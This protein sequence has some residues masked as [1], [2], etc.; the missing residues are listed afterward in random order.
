MAMDLDISRT[1]AVLLPGYMSLAQSAGKLILGKVA[2]LPNTDKVAMYQVA[3]LANC[4]ATTLCPIIT[5]YEGLIVYTVVFGLADGC[6][7]A[8]NMLVVG[9]L[10]SK[11]QL[12]LGYSV[13]LVTS[14]ASFLM[15]PPVAGM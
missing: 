9:D 7:S 12:S 4:L 13:F 8:N 2:T 1:K 15:G 3:L 10:V 11:K 5:S 14:A 6:T